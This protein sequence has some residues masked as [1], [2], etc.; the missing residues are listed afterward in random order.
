MI[1]RLLVGFTALFGSYLLH[2]GVFI[3]NIEANFVDIRGAQLNAFAFKLYLLLAAVW[4]YTSKLFHKSIFMLKKQKT[5]NWIGCMS[6]RKLYVARRW[7]NKY[8]L[9]IRRQCTIWWK[10][11]RLLKF[12]CEIFPKF[13]LGKPKMAVS[14]GWCLPPHLVCGN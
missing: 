7:V 9:V 1:S 11:C 2:C 12:E 4:G 3:S 5:R 8:P 10:N 6:A 13:N 14:S